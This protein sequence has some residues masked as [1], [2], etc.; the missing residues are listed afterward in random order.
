MRKLTW[1][2]MYAFIVPEEDKVF[3]KS[4]FLKFQPTGTI[5]TWGTMD[6]SGDVYQATINDYLT[7]WVYSKDFAVHMKVRKYI[8]Q[9]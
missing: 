2:S 4:D 3:S 1:F 7:K 9:K 5:F 8:F 6:G